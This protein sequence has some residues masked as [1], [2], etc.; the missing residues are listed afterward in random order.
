[1]ANKLLE[2]VNALGRDAALAAEYEAD[3]DAVLARYGLSDEQK[4]AMKAGD[5]AAVAKLCGG[6]SDSY[7]ANNTT[8]KAYDH[9][10]DEY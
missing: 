1:M 7:Y 5:C 4:A 10:D 6:D 2:L 3:P 8:I 9:K